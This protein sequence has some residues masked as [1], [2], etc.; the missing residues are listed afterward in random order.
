[1]I[2]AKEEGSEED[3]LSLQTEMSN[4]Y[5]EF[6]SQYIE[7]ILELLNQR[8][9]YMD[10]SYYSNTLLTITRFAAG[11][12][13]IFN[14]GPVVKIV[15]TC[16]SDTKYYGIWVGNQVGLSRK[17]VTL[18]HDNMIVSPHPVNPQGRWWRDSFKVTVEGKTLIVERTDY[19][20]GWGQQLQLRG[21]IGGIRYTY[22]VNKNFQTQ[23][24]RRREII[25][26]TQRDILRFTEENCQNERTLVLRADS[27]NGCGIVNNTLDFRTS[28]LPTKTLSNGIVAGLNVGDP[29]YNTATA[30]NS[31]INRNFDWNYK[32]YPYEHDSQFAS[33]SKY[34][35]GEMY[36]S[37]RENTATL[38]NDCS[39]PDSLISISP[40][41]QLPYC[42]SNKY[43]QVKGTC[44]SAITLAGPDNYNYPLGYTQLTELWTKVS[45]AIP[46][47]TVT[48]GNA[49][50]D[51]AQDSCAKWQAMFNEW[52]K[53]ED[54][55]AISPCEPER[56]IQPTYD[57]V[58][59]NMAQEWN[60]SATL[61]IESL[62]K[63]LEI[64]Q[65]YIETYPNILQLEESGVTLGPP[66]LG[67]SMLLQYK[68]DQLTPGVAPV[69]YL[70]MLV[71]NGQDGDQGEIGK[72]GLP[73]AKS[74]SVNSQGP[75][76]PTGNPNLPTI[77]DR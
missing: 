14:F 12:P 35:I 17:L 37:I 47:N 10:G 30:V 34:S 71:P 58:L 66:S 63:R 31:T 52:R 77:F 26:N 50:L 68:V 21:C 74:S 51:S 69:Q 67:G 64:I 55:A 5:R 54:A 13:S 61:Y 76:G 73:G 60:K 36:R 4:A 22:A 38:Y 59:L 43:A 48:A 49:I 46:G 42:I 20:W 7:P 44:D 1:M 11:H 29:Q 72:F 16:G 70:T 32:D 75:V 33:L 6:D 45:N 53:E 41:N 40:E 62:M 19:P 9:M 57:P 15:T 2:S 24:S 3:V 39:N 27:S 56:A 25:M 65:K 8:K 23:M 28:M 18:P